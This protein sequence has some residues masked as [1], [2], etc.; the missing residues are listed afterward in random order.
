MKPTKETTCRACGKP[1]IFIKTKIGRSTPCDAE[2]VYIRQDTKG[3]VFVLPYGGTVNGFE[4][5]DA[6]D[7]PDTNLIP[8]YR[9]HFATCTNPDD[10]RRKRKR[11]RKRP[12]GYR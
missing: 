7:D 5:G 8:V 2:P 6:Y 4:V 1:I 9:S 11:E 12:S 3:D 10:F